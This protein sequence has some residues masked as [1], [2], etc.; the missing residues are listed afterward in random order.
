MNSLY[1]SLQY[2]KCYKNVFWIYQRNFML[3]L[4]Y[5]YFYIALNRC[6]TNKIKN[7]LPRR[8]RVLILFVLIA[9]ICIQKIYNYKPYKQIEKIYNTY[10]YI[11]YVTKIF[12]LFYY[13][14]YYY[15]MKIYTTQVNRKVSFTIF[16]HRL[17][18]F[19]HIFYWHIVKIFLQKRL[20]LY[21]TV[22]KKKCLQSYLFCLLS[23]IGCIFFSVV[24]SW[25][26]SAVVQLK[27]L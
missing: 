5:F 17:K 14:F 24:E 10:M 6:S 22:Y 15:S 7:L 18:F 2:V 19:C 20:K 1:N 9:L 11:V 4:I 21:T 16:N 26:N 3:A 13:F 25:K 23:K 8:I 12:S 27:G